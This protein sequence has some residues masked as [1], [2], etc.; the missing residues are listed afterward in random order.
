[1][2]LTE[3]AECWPCALAA[4]QRAQSDGIAHGLLSMCLSLV[5]Q[6]RLSQAPSPSELA[7]LVKETWSGALEPSPAR[8]QACTLLCALAC[9]DGHEVEQLLSWSLGLGQSDATL[10]LLAL[11]VLQDLAFEVFHRPLQSKPLTRLLESASSDVL[12]YLDDC[13]TTDGLLLL[14]LQ[15]R[16]RVS[17]LVLAIVSH[18]GI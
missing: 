16:P 15:A 7:P 2:K 8:R 10:N 5:R 17:Y 9:V 12:S 4:L 6:A 1:M 11:H 18:I 14:S 13:A 3:I